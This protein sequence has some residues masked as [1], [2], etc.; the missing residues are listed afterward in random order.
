MCDWDSQTFSRHVHLKTVKSQACFVQPQ[1]EGEIPSHRGVCLIQIDTVASK[2]PFFLVYLFWYFLELRLWPEQVELLWGCDNG[3]TSLLQTKRWTYD[4]RIIEDLK[5]KPRKL[6]T[7]GKGNWSRKRQCWSSMC[8]VLY[9]I[10]I[11]WNWIAMSNHVPVCQFVDSNPAPHQTSS[12]RRSFVVV[13]EGLELSQQ[14]QA[15]LDHLPAAGKSSHHHYIRHNKQAKQHSWKQQC[16][17]M[18]PVFPLL[19]RWFQSLRCKS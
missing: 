7:C 16:N 5:N 12:S 2:T 4:H 17:Q 6:E 3:T 11:G 19:N 18:Y 14:F 10:E 9:K 13:Q 15:L 1:W 8:P